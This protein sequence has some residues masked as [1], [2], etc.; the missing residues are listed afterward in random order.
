MRVKVRISLREKGE[1]DEEALSCAATATAAEARGGPSEAAD[2]AEADDASVVSAGR[3]SG[4]DEP[5]REGGAKGEPIGEGLR[6]GL[7]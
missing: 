3:T 1:S 4:G 6:L 5:R 7:G 2:G